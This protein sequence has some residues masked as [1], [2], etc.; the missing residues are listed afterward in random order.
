MS[1]VTDDPKSP[2]LKWGDPDETPVKQNDCYLVLSAAER[3]KGF[4]RPYRDSYIHAKSL[5]GCGAVT[6]MGRELSETYARDPHFYGSTYC[7]GC[8]RHRPV[9]TAG[10]FY[11]D[12]TADKVGT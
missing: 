7:V 4:L 9:G 12:N 1:G 6:R 5:G 3:A 11:W 8:S 2:C 10:E